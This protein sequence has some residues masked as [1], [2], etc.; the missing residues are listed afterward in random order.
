MAKA[1]KRILISKVGLDAHWRGAMVVTRALC[2]AGFEVLLGRNLSPAAIVTTAIQ[3]GVDYIGISSL[4]GNHL[5]T[6]PRV[7]DLL[8]SHRAEDI[9]VVV[10]GIVPPGDAQK[11][12]DYGVLEVFGPGHSTQ[13]IAEF[14]DRH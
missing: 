12:K 11:L 10:G 14:L 5:A 13:A 2:D 7:L 8:R 6:V 4:S 3:E 1:G 9:R